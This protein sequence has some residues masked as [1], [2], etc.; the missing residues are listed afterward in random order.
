MMEK[1]SL[2]NELKAARRALNSDANRSSAVRNRI[3]DIVYAFQDYILTDNLSTDNL[4]VAELFYTELY[5][6]TDSHPDHI[7]AADLL[8]QSIRNVEEA[9]E[10][11]DDN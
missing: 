2:Q 11:G 5:D 8:D 1:K 3:T 10:I 9:L 7:H 6:A 4:S